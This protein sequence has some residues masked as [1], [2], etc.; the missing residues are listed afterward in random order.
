[1]D[2]GS[3]DAGDNGPVVDCSQSTFGGHGALLRMAKAAGTPDDVAKASYFLA[4]GQLS[5]IG[6]TAFKDYGHENGLLGVDS[7]NVGFREFITPD[8]Y[9]NSPMVVKSERQ[10]Y[11]GS[12][13]SVL[14]YAFHDMYE[15]Y[16]SYGRYIWNDLR[17]YER[18]RQLYFP[19][20]DTSKGTHA[21]LGT[22]HACRENPCHARQRE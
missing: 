10:E 1:M 8:S 2:D 4:K 12:Y 16:Y 9:A 7:I 20:S 21:E 18:I 14:C 6:R 3:N 15:T 17:D 5:L 19:N 11:D 22:R 13:D